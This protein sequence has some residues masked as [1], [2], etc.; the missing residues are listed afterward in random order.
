MTL[1]QQFGVRQR[2]TPTRSTPT[3]MPLAEYKI[4]TDNTVN[5]TDAP[6]AIDGQ[7]TTFCQHTTAGDLWIDLGGWYKIQSIM[8][9]WHTG[10]GTSTT[11]EVVGWRT[12]DTTFSSSNGSVSFG[13]PADTDNGRVDILEP[14]GTAQRFIRYIRFRQTGGNTGLRIYNIL[15]S[16]S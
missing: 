5:V 6:N 4:F 8:V 2:V 7:E 10:T 1:P 12:S 16:T 15:V 11:M 13:T 14:T 3:F 9:K